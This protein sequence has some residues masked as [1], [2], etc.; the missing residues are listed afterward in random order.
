MNYEYIYLCHNVPTE[1]YLFFMVS[2]TNEQDKS[3]DSN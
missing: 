1:M 2:S 3:S